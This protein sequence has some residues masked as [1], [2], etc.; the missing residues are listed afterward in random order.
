MKC[1]IIQ[2]APDSGKAYILEKGLTHIGRSVDNEIQLMY[3]Q[4]SRRHAELDNAEDECVLKDHGSANGTSVNGG[5]IKET[6]LHHGDE[7][8]IGECVL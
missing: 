4:I 8:K 6:R 1:R 5:K 3:D 2:I 7:I